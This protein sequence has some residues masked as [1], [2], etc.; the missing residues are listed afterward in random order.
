[1]SSMGKQDDFITLKEAA[2]IT[3]YAPDYIGQLI[4][5]GKLDGKQVYSNVAWVTTREALEEYQ[6]NKDKKADE[7]AWFERWKKQISSPE[8]LVEIYTYAAWGFVAL[9]VVVILFLL[10][11]FAVSFDNRISARNL[12]ETQQKGYVE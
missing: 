7:R 4:R 5:A 3:G 8:T 12:Q 11:V 1:M 6:K 2:Q 10:Y 9:L